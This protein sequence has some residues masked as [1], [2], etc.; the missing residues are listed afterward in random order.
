MRRGDTGPTL[1]ALARGIGAE[2]VGWTCRY[3]AKRVRADRDLQAALG[4]SGL[5][6]PPVHDA[7]VV[8]PETAPPATAATATAAFIPVAHAGAR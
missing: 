8:E 3:D 4:E 1:R 5:R 7:L 2:V 6:A